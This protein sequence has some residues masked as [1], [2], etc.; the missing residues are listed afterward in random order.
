MTRWLGRVR[1]MDVALD[2]LSSD[3]FASKTGESALVDARHHVQR[4]RQS[5]RDKMLRRLAE[6]DPA[7]LGRKLRKLVEK[8][9]SV[10]E[11][12][13]GAWR[14]VLATRLARRTTG[15]RQAIAEAGSIY[16]PERLHGVRLAAK[17]LRYAL[18]IAA[19]LGVADAAKHAA[20]IRRA[21]VTLGTLQDRHLLARHLRTFPEAGTELASLETALEGGCRE[22][23]GQFLSQRES[24]L[25]ALAAVRQ[26]VIPA[27]T[28]PERRRPLKALASMVMHGRSN[29][30]VPDPTRNRRRARRRLA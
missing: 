3:E 14:R 24:L 4:A 15:L 17:K 13:G 19:E 16:V 26:Q 28:H 7:R 10:A 18:E 29:R 1:E 27:L 12:S 25:A 9:V 11:G 2:L 8:S 22:L 30:A 6:L 23:H 21:Q 20:T 5:R